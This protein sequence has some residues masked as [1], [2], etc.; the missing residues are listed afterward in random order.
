MECLVCKKELRKS[1]SVF[2]NEEYLRDCL[3]ET[4][5][6]LRQEVFPWYAAIIGYIH[7]RCVRNPDML[8]NK[9]DSFRLLLWYT[10]Q[11]QERVEIISIFV[12]Q[13]WTFWIRKAGKE[14]LQSIKCFLGTHRETYRMPEDTRLPRCRYCYKDMKMSRKITMSLRWNWFKCWLGYHSMLTDADTGKTDC[15]FCGKDGP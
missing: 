15:Q 8:P 1:D 10:T 5:E 6:R 11:L 13:K 3:P 7:F 14:I 9:D 4:Y 12:D 2:A